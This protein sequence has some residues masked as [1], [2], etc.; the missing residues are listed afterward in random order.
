MCVCVRGW[1]GGWVMG[2]AGPNA[3]R[4]TGG[5]GSV[6]CRGRRTMFI[7]SCG[8]GARDRKPGGWLACATGAERGNMIRHV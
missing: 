6:C 7:D 8:Q 4:K 5:R 3:I 1:V 2:R